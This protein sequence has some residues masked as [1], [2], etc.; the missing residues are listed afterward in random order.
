MTGYR[1][2]HF[3]HRCEVDG[4]YVEQLPSWDDLIEAFPRR[5]RP[6]DIDGMVEINGQFLFIEEKCAGKG[7]DEGQRRALKAVSSLP[8]V[9]VLIFRPVADGEPDPVEVLV[10]PNTQGWR[11]VTR[12]QLRHW[13]TVWAVHADRKKAA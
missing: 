13:L 9:T 4:C 3:R 1:S 11:R 12:Q 7:P 8:G 10:F 2:C 6:T 5:I